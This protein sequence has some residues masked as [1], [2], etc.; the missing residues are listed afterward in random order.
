MLRQIALALTTL[1]FQI[2]PLHAESFTI[3][4]NTGGDLNATAVATF[5][6]PWAMDFV[7]DTQLLV[8]T[9]PGKLWLVSTDGTKQR[10]SGV[11]RPE[12]GGQGGLGDVVLHPVFANNQLVYLSYVES[13]DG[14]NTRGAVVV[15]GRLT[16]GD[17]P[18]ISDIERVWSQYPHRPGSGHFS[19]RVAFGPDGT[20]HAGKLLITSGDRQEQ[21]PAQRWDMA[22]GKIIRLN[23]DGTVPPDNPYQDQGELAKSF[24]TLGHRNLLG[25]AFDEQ[26]QLWSHEMD[27]KHGDE[28]NL[29]HVG[30]NYGWPVVSEGDQYSGKAIPDHDTRPDFAPPSASW[31]PSIAPSGLVIY[32]GDM[33]PDWQGDAFIGG[34]VSRALIRVELDGDKARE[35]ERFEWNKRVREVEQGPDGAIWVLEDKTGARLL[36][37]SAK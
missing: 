8:T 10:V 35:A 20:K 29:I 28:L 11:P 37:L 5:D 33:F 26:G 25:I 3:Q 17:T 9:K 32:T 6:Q 7:S 15:R 30:K 24:W 4:G 36:R 13:H 21:T 27:P 14:G 19:H 12:V 23:L 1:A 22:L 31:V 18:Q 2:A 34:L 16:L